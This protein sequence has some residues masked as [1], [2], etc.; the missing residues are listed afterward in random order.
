MTTCGKMIILLTMLTTGGEQILL[1]MVAAKWPP[2]SRSPSN[3]SPPCCKTQF[4]QSIF[5]LYGFNLWFERQSKLFRNDPCRWQSNKE[6]SDLSPTFSKFLQLRVEDPLCNYSS[7]L[8][9]QWARERIAL[10]AIWERETYLSC[11]RAGDIVH[12]GDIPRQATLSRKSLTQLLKVSQ[13]YNKTIKRYEL[14]K[15]K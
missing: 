1:P 11:A 5:L 13:P 14:T 8:P 10:L 2:G 3:C 9:W 7:R 6:T 12:W 4:P 15:N